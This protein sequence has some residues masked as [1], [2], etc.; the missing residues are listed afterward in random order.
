MCHEDAGMYFYVDSAE[1]F[2]GRI[3]GNVTILSEEP[4]YRHIPR[5][6]LKLSTKISMIVSDRLSMVKMVHLSYKDKYCFF[7]SRQ[8]Y[9]YSVTGPGNTCI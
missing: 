2:A 9:R 4:F 7:V 5:T 1:E 8:Q 3:G 6:G